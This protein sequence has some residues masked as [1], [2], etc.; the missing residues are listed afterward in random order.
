VSFAAHIRFGYLAQ[1]A[2]LL[3][4]A[5]VN[6]A[7]PNW[8]GVN[9][10]AALSE[11]LAF[12]GVTCIVFNEGVSYM[13][14]RRIR[15][16]CVRIENAGLVLSQAA[17]EHFVLVCMTLGS[18][19]GLTYVLNPAHHYTSYD[20]LLV[21]V[22]G[23]V[24]AAYIPSVAVLTA[25]MR[26]HVLLALTLSNGVLSF[27][28]PV[29]LHHFSMDIRLS[30][31]LTYGLC[32]AGGIAYF[33]VQGMTGYFHRIKLRDRIF[34]RMSLL[35]LIAPTALRIAIIWVPVIL[36][37]NAGGAVDAA[38]YKIAASIAFGALAF[39][40]FNKQTMISVDGIAPPAFI[41]TIASVAILLTGLGAVLLI[42]IAEP[43]TRF[44]YG[45]DFVRLAEYLPAL[46]PF[47]VLQTVVDIAL[48]GLISTKKDKLTFALCLTSVV[49]AT[50]A[51]AFLDARWY[52]ALCAG[53]FC[54]L[55]AAIMPKVFYRP[56]FFRGLVA[57]TTAVSAAYVIDGWMGLATGLG[58]LAFAL[59]LDAGLRECVVRFAFHLAPLRKTEL[60][61]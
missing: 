49:V 23:L 60:N 12:V 14:I 16:T 51:L 15:E 20:W 2:S 55:F 48:V 42:G 17:F 4:L 50:T 37:A 3:S 45:A 47:L 10:F 56:T 18:V 44:L 9:A 34:L 26:N 46:G 24:V 13:V 36:F 27:I 6:I 59:V 41:A 35:P 5:L 52:P 25:T 7:L 57:S 53:L 31:A 11:A 61:G 21:C 33:S 58:V 1:M 19:I 28:L 30:I 38:T 43:L 54:A 39:V 40:P 32:F 29:V 22:T 8:L